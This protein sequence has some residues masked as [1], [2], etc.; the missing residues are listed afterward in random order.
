MVVF[1]EKYPTR[2]VYFRG[3]TAIR[4]RLYRSLISK[5]IEII[6]FYFHV[7]G[8]DSEGQTEKFVKNQDYHAFIIYQHEKK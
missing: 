8:L 4:T 5:C 3:S 7:A 1:F 2:K 6:E